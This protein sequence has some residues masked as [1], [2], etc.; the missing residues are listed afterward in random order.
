MVEWREAARKYQKARLVFQTTI[1]SGLDLMREKGCPR[2][3][4]SGKARNRQTFSSSQANPL[5]FS[6]HAVE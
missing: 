5:S 1:D 2:G 4:I 3:G 6:P